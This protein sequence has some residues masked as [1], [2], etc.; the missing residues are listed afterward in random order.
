MDYTQC[1]A[2][3][4]TWLTIFGIILIQ[5]KVL[6]FHWEM[7]TSF[8]LYN[9]KILFKKAIGPCQTIWETLKY[10]MHTV[11]NIYSIYIYSMTL[12][13]MDTPKTITLTNLTTHSMTAIQTWM[14]TAQGSGPLNK[15]SP[16]NIFLS[17]L[18]SWKQYLAAPYHVH[19]RQESLS[20]SAPVKYEKHST[21]LIDTLQ[22]Q[23]CPKQRSYWI[24]LQ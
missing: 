23:K 20:C 3:L 4:L 10:K 19:I 5:L 7:L 9:L 14:A 1:S 17:F 11:H 6:F 12:V 16:F 15:F 2:I 24:E 18:V 21:D 8:E 13:I 22:K